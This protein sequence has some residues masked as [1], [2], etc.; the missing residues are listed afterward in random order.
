LHVANVDS[1]WNL[2]Y[3]TN[4]SGTWTQSTVTSQLQSYTALRVAVDAAVSPR[5]ALSWQ[6]AT[7]SS[8]YAFAAPC[9]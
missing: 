1:K 3:A 9:K 7:G 8:R 4:A 5:I 2:V 6:G